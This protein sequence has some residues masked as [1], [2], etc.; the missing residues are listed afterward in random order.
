MSS[1]LQWMLITDKVDI[2]Q[3]AERSG[4]HRIFLDLEFMGKS[5]RQGHLNTHKATHTLDDVHAVGAVLERAELMVRVNPLHNGTGQEVTSALEAGAQRLML[6][7]FSRSEE[8]RAFAD[9]VD[10]RAP[11]SWLAETPAALARL[12]DWLDYLR[13]GDEVHF[14]LNDLS[15]AMSLGF[16][17][18]PMAGRMFDYAA[19]LLNERG[20]PFGIG[21]VARCGQGALPAEWVVGEHVRLGSTRLILSRAFRGDADDLDSFKRTMDLQSEL[22]KLRAIEGSWRV[23]SADALEANFQRLAAKVFEIARGLR[24]G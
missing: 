4:V 19:I 2:A 24:G 22:E 3:H 16:L 14:G 9:L 11:V 8:V 1:Q 13:P 15:L 21:G 23:A 18:E 10:G 17:F 20:I 12:L 6:P 5:D 7:M